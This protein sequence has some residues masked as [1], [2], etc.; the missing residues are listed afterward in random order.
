[1]EITAEETVQQRIARLRAE[2]AE[3]SRLNE[4]YFRIGHSWPVQQTH[5][6]RRQRLEQIVAELKILANGKH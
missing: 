2:V 6:E 4:E 5:A 1:M 3:I